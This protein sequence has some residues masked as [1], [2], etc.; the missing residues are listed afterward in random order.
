MKKFEVGKI[1][2]DK[3]GIDIEIMDRTDDSVTIR[4]IKKDWWEQDTKK[5]TEYKIKTCCGDYESISLE[6]HHAA[7]MIS[8]IDESDIKIEKKYRL[9]LENAPFYM[10]IDSTKP[11]FLKYRIEDGQYVISSAIS[12][13]YDQT[14]FTQKEIDK[15]K[16]RFRTNLKEFR[17]EEVEE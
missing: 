5:E 15:I 17:I 8:A 1:Y 16:R 12:S 13:I 2:T 11:R 6:D 4:H 10:P 9:Y 3:D 7:P 14:K